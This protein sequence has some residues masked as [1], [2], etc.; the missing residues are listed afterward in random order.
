MTIRIISPTILVL[1]EA[2]HSNLHTLQLA[3]SSYIHHRHRTQ[4]MISNLE[5]YQLCE[6]SQI[7]Y[8]D[9][10]VANT[11]VNDDLSHT[12]IQ[13][14]QLIDGPNSRIWILLQVGML[15]QSTNIY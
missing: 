9:V 3:Q 1:S 10:R 7:Q 4:T 12:R 15:S 14:H 2:V 13:R 5:R 6:S 8:S 11:V